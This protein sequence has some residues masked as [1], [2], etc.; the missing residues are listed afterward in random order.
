MRKLTASCSF[1]LQKLQVQITEFGQQLEAT[2][3]RRF[4]KLFWL[5][6]EL[7]PGL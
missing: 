6:D 5:L 1:L 2:A 4:R 7:H 3:K